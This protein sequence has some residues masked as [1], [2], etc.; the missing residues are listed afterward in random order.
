MA[1]VKV[2]RR[3]S[4]FLLTTLVAA[5]SA[6]SIGASSAS[7]SA[8][9]INFHHEL[10]GRC[11]DSNYN[12]DVYTL[13]CNGGTYQL[14]Y[15]MQTSSGI[16]FMDAATGRCLDNSTGYGDVYTTYPC[17]GGVYQS[18]TNWYSNGHSVWQNRGSG[19]TLDGNGSRVYA[20]YFYDNV[21]QS[22]W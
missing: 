6:V 8:A 11:L 16:E 7:A 14:W 4:V 12:G 2:V 20:N 18:W 19:M 1:K 3:V 21:N 10:D 15:L 13:P 5:V 17:T 9:P 22:W